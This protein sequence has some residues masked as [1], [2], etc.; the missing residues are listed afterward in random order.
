VRTE[1]Q[2]S[3]YIVHWG[4]P[5]PR[6]I[7]ADLVYRVANRGNDQQIGFHNDLDHRAFLESLTRTKKRYAF[8]LFGHG[9]MSNHFHLL[10][11]L[12]AGIKISRVMQSLSVAHTVRYHKKYRSVGYVCQGRFRCPWSKTMVTCG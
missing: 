3:H 9:L 4:R 2:I 11:R 12:E 6:P 7:D 8:R 1:F 5:P 10:I